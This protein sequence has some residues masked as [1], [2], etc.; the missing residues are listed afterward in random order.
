M[1]RTITDIHFQL[2]G[3]LHRRLQDLARTQDRTLS[4]VMRQA[5]LQYVNA[6][7]AIASPLDLEAITN[8]ARQS[9][10]RKPGTV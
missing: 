5:A 1:P 3:Y 9:T 10:K 7:P 4:S 2:D 6:H 8:A